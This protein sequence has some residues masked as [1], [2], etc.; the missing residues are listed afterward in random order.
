MQKILAILKSIINELLI[1]FILII[2]INNFIGNVDITIKADGIGYY[3]YLPSIFIHH[4]INRHTLKEIKEPE[5][6]NRIN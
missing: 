5:K 1:V 6:F 3:D 2:L 4:D